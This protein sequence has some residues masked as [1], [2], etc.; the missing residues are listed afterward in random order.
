MGTDLVFHRISE[1]WKLVQPSAICFTGLSPS[2]APYAPPNIS[3]PLDCLLPSVPFTSSA[4]C[5]CCITSQANNPTSLPLTP[6]SPYL[7]RTSSPEPDGPISLV[8]SGWE[9]AV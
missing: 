5:S 1:V 3:K 8:V 6:Q 7:L 2:A 4:C 9:V